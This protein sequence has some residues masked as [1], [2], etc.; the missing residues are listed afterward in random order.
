[1]RH[2]RATRAQSPERSQVGGDEERANEGIRRMRKKRIDRDIW[3]RVREEE[4][5]KERKRDAL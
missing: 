1:M 3:T 5:G 2:N 4:R